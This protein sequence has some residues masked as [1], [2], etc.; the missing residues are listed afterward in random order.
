MGMEK[1][2]FR[3]ENKSSVNPKSNFSTLLETPQMN[4]SLHLMRKTLS[5]SIITSKACLKG[6]SP[7]EG[8]G[9]KRAR[10]S[11]GRK[12]ENPRERPPK[13]PKEPKNPKRAKNLP[14]RAKSL[15]PRKLNVVKKVVPRKKELRKEPKNPEKLKKAKNPS[16][17]PEKAKEPSR[18]QKK[19]KK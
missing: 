11:L 1:A 18:N 17:D 13:G 6:W 14:E 9:P 7:K 4:N 5:R 3:K 2:R 16:K 8:V 15:K 10:E 19:P 12:V